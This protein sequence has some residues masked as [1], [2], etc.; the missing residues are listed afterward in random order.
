MY[1]YQIRPSWQALSE[2]IVTANPYSSLRFT[3]LRAEHWPSWYSEV[4]ARLDFIVRGDEIAYVSS[5]LAVDDSIAGELFVLT[6]RF[7]IR[8]DVSELEPPRRGYGSVRAVVWSR[9]DLD[10]VE[11]LEVDG[12][13]ELPEGGTRFEALRL[14]LTYR[15]RSAI[16]LPVEAR[17]GGRAVSAL[18]KTFPALLDDISLVSP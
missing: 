11:V 12:A 17:T 2:Q 7:A 5:S 1:R 14:K 9:S 4:L 10:E 16:T 3:Q 8:V 18:E 15:G 6:D 13:E